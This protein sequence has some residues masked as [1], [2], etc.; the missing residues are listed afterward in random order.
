MRFFIFVVVGLFFCVHKVSTSCVVDKRLVDIFLKERNLIHLFKTLHIQHF[1]TTALAT[2][3]TKTTTIATK[4][5]N[6]T[7]RQEFIT[8][9]MN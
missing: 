8:G 1:T 5:S 2:C 4:K 7:R 6:I 3:Y 9:A